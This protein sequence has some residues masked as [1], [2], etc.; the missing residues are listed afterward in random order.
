M[1]NKLA[2]SH[3][4]RGHPPHSTVPSPYVGRG[5]GGGSMIDKLAKSHEARGQSPHST[6]PSPYVGRDRVG[7]Q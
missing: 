5:Q 4:A 6:V 7:G 1:T 3:E 2:T